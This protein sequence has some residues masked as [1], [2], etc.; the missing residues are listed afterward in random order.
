MPNPTKIDHAVK[1]AYKLI[2]LAAS[3]EEIAEALEGQDSAGHQEV[4]RILAE[5]RDGYMEEATEMLYNYAI[6]ARPVVRPTGP[7]VRPVA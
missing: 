7:T 4:R 6:G 1:E 3:S 5:L 2:R